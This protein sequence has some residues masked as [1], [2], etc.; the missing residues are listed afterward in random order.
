MY[1]SEYESSE[2]SDLDDD[3]D[4]TPDS[5]DEGR[6]EDT[7]EAHKFQVGSAAAAALS[8]VLTTRLPSS[9]KTFG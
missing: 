2:L 1:E 9:V 4:Y 7:F 6:S 8:R 3:S 5:E